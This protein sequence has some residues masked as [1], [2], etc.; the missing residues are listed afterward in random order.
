MSRKSEITTI[1]LRVKTRDRIREFGKKG[2]SYD[3]VI[4]GVLDKVEKYEK[5]K[6]P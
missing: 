5:G 2:D 3:T 6:S 4:W 1:R